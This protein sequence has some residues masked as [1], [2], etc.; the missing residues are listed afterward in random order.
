MKKLYWN[1]WWWIRHNWAPERY[2]WAVEIPNERGSWQCFYALDRA[3]AI[4]KG[5]KMFGLTA[6]VVQGD[7]Y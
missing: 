5:Q 4:Q 6:Y 7:G 2:C 3:S 1:I